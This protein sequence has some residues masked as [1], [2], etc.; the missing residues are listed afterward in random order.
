[1]SLVLPIKQRI[2]KN[3]KD[4]IKDTSTL[5]SV[6]NTND[7][8]AKN[9]FPTVPHADGKSVILN[10]KSRFFT[11]DIPYGLCVLKSIADMFKVDVPNIERIIK[12][13]QKFMDVKILG[14]D[15]KFIPSSIPS[16]GIPQ[17]YGVTNA[18]ELV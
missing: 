8:Y 16:S 15:N 10:T 4:S 9:V 13:H 3:Y 12:W 7:G 5:K 17:K 6:F 1:M 2:I 14:D 11:E 18:Y